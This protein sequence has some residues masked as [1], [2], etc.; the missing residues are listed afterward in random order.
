MNFYASPSILV[1]L[2]DGPYLN[3]LIAVQL[4][5]NG[6]NLLALAAISLVNILVAVK[7]TC[8]PILDTPF[9]VMLLVVMDIDSS[10]ND[11]QHVY[12]VQISY[13]VRAVDHGIN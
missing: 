9:H 10:L 4:K 12:S 6:I 1:R 5:I 13:T 7:E 11:D 8:L 3:Y 2:H